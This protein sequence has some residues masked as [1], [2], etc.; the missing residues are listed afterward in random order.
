MG[1]LGYG[2]LGSSVNEQSFVKYEDFINNNRTSIFLV[3]SEAHE[4]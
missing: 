1:A 4:K 3:T 2:L